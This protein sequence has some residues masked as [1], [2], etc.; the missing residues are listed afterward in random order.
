MVKSVTPPAMSAVSESPA[1]YRAFAAAPAHIL[2]CRRTEAQMLRT[3]PTVQQVQIR[4]HKMH[5]LA[6]QENGQTAK[7]QERR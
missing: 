1:K 6:A 5:L 4:G 7:A 3:T 2:R